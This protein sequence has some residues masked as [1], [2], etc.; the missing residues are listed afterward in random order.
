[1]Q[2]VGVGVG[3]GAGA[4]PWLACHAP[5]SGRR[6]YGGPPPGGRTGRGGP[7][8]GCYA[9]GPAGITGLTTPSGCAAATS[10]PRPALLKPVKNICLN[11]YVSSLKASPA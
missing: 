9:G 1:M 7:S 4:A 6:G 3:A 5:P 2:A 10:Q 11:M 8:G